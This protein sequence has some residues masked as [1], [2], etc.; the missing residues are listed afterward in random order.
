M[1][2]PFHLAWFL[3]GHDLDVPVEELTTNGHPSSRANFLKKA[4]GHTL[5]EA[6]I[7]CTSHGGSVDL[8][9]TPDTVVAQTAEAMH[10]VG[11]DGV[12]LVLPDASRKTVAEVADGRVP[13]L[14]RRGLVRRSDSHTQF[15]DNLL[16][17]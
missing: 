14:Q 11:G 3:S 17:F 9:G 10:E 1:A 8:V 2:D 13:A 7:A 5:R 16:E 15:R 12:P 4:G 6:I